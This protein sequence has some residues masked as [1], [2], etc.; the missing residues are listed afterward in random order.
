MFQPCKVWCTQ[1]IFGMRNR[2][3]AVFFLEVAEKIRQSVSTVFI[4]ILDILKNFYVFGLKSITV[5][6][7]YGRFKTGISS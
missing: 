3:A 2:G 5:V 7:T 6:D 1:A 4:K